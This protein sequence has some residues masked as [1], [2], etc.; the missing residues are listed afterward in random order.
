MRG[1]K[2]CDRGRAPAGRRN[3][4]ERVEMPELRR[5]KIPLGIAAKLAICMVAGSA[6]FFALFGYINIREQKQH[7]EELILQSAERVGDI[8]LRSTRY[9]MLHNDRLA[10]YQA[11]TDIGSEPGIRRIRI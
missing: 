3:W 11:I 9:Q 2:R 4:C 5:S 8:V 6:A 10:L 1:E 7:S